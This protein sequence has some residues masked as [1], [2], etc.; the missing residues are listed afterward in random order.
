MDIINKFN[1]ILWEINSK[2]FIPYDVMPYFIREY[3]SS[4]QKT[5][6]K[7]F[8]EFK[9][10]VKAKSL[11]MYWA[12]CEYEIL[13]SDWPNHSDT[14]KVDVHWQ[15]MMNLDLVTKILMDNVTK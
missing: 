7:T 13:L 11:Y 15:I 5:K 8:D 2:K 10:F 6:P 4:K 12:R 3:K 1:V 9:Q 14:M